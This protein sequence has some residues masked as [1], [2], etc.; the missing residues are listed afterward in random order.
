MTDCLSHAIHPP[1][2]TSRQLSLG[3]LLLIAAMVQNHAQ[4]GLL[5]SRRFM[6]TPIAAYAWLCLTLRILFQLP[7]WRPDY[8]TNS[9][10]VLLGLRKVYSSSMAAPDYPAEMVFDA[11]VLILIVIQRR[12]FLSPDFQR[13]VN[14]L[15]CAVLLSLRLK[16][17][18]RLSRPTY[19]TD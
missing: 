9:P 13:V 3:Y 5:T 17:G 1:I 8:G 15:W 4:E 7:A 18:Q 10:Q 12:I 11:V 14:E 19:L 16:N 6:W 2:R